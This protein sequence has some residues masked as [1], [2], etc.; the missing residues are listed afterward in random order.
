MD[1]NKL[2]E[3]EKLETAYL[4]RNPIETS[5]RAAYRRKV[6]LAL[7]QLQQLDATLTKR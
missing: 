5:D 2:Q 3:L 6:I 1:V 7:P 4:E